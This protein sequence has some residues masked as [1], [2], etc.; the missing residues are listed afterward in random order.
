AALKQKENLASGVAEN[1][2][3]EAAP[4]PCLNDNIKA[5]VWY[6][7]IELSR[8]QGPPPPYPILPRRPPAA[9]LKSKL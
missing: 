9:K 1:E 3:D 7:Y 4:Q 5:I 2:I 6:S 8:I